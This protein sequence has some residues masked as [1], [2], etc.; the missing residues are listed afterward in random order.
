MDRLEA[1]IEFGLVDAG[2]KVWHRQTQL[3]R[4]ELLKKLKK[5]RKIPKG[6]DRS[7]PRH[8][9]AVVGADLIGLRLNEIQST[10]ARHDELWQ[11]RDSFACRN[12]RDPLVRL[13]SELVL[14]ARDGT[15]IRPD[16]LAVLASI[17][18]VVGDKPGPVLITQKT[19]RRRALG[20]KTQAVFVAEFAGRADGAKPL[21]PSR[22]RTLLDRLYT[23]KFFAR[24]TYGCRL[25]YYSHRMSNSQL[26]K[27]VY[28]RKTYPFTSKRLAQIDDEAMTNAIRN[29]RAAAAGKPP[30]APN[31]GPMVLLGKIAPEDAI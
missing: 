18:S 23:R 8:L 13:K 30:P 3:Q 17:F 20:Y 12:G 4:Q 5:E 11:F 31:A 21:T 14:E 26:R 29:E 7:K 27:A 16:E 1:I 2:E 19:I 25:T 28:D 15:G 10:L 24:T 22:L 9:H 6:F